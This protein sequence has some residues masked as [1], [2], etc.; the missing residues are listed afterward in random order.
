MLANDDHK[1]EELAF[2]KKALDFTRAGLILTNPALPDNPIVYAN[3][4]FLDMTGYTKEEIV[5]QN[6][7]FLQGEKTNRDTVQQIR[8]AIREEKS[9][10]VQILNYTK[11]N[12]PFWN[13]L[14]IDPTWIDDEIYFIGVQKDITEKKKQEEVIY[15]YY[16]KMQEMSAPIVPVKDGVSVLPIVG[17]LNEQRYHMIASKVSTYIDE[18]KD[19]HF[20]IDF[21]G[22]LEMDEDV[23]AYIYNLHDLIKITGTEVIVTGITPSVAKK[24]RDLQVNFTILKTYTH[25]KAALKAIGYA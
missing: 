2:I 7:R 23:V 20:I 22:L 8:D 19:D 15:D 11:E 6:C 4:G 25:V 16:E 13:D 5:G 12:Q 1:V 18:S 14:F 3:Q 17:V 24:M 10:N 9:V 21:S